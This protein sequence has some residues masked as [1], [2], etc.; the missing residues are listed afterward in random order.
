MMHPELHL[1]LY[2]NR[3]RELEQRSARARLAELVRNGK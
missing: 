2:L 3:L 1:E